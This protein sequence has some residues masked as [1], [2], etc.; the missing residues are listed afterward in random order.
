MAVSWVMVFVRFWKLTN[1]IEHGIE[2]GPL[3]DFHVTAQH[4]EMQLAI[5]K[6]ESPGVLEI[7][8]KTEF[9]VNKIEPLRPV[10]REVS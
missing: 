7:G 3:E 6:E 8:N 4:I 5:H 1:F 2:H 9:F 10:F